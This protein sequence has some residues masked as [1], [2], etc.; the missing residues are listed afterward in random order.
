MRPRTAK[1]G[2]VLLA[3][4]PAVQWPVSDGLRDT[5]S[6]AEVRSNFWDG[7]IAGATVPD[8][9]TRGAPNP[10]GTNVEVVVGEDAGA[11]E[12]EDAGLPEDAGAQAVGEDAGAE[13]AGAED[14]GEEDA[15][16]AGED[17]GATPMQAPM[18]PVAV[19][20][21]PPK[22]N[23]V[24]GDPSIYQLTG[25]GTGYGIGPGSTGYGSGQGATGAWIGPG[26]TG[27]GSGEGHTG[28]GIG[29]GSTGY[30]SGQGATGDGIGPNT[31]TKGFGTWIGTGEGSSTT[32]FGT[33]EGI[34]PN[35]GT[36][37]FGTGIGIGQDST[38]RGAN[39]GFWDRDGGAR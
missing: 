15:G 6:F 18:P 14:A 19:E 38:G 9:G 17:G 21:R 32:E 20:V 39:D 34:G 11:E 31:G 35:T 7:L 36:K 33:G 3:M 29:P 2:Y 1:F 26:S 24:F 13:D 25:S 28:A 4:M 23:L 30:G 5:V 16:D 37:G 22:G 27:L 12:L 8:G 10:Q